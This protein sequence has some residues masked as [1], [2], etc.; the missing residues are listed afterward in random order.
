M[1]HV[2]LGLILMVS[3]SLIGCGS[4]SGGGPKHRPAATIKGF[5]VDAQIVGGTVSVFGFKNG[6]KG[7]LL[8]SAITDEQGF[9]RIDLAAPDQHILIEVKGGSY[10]EEA[11]G[12]G[13]TLKES[14]FMRAVTFYRSG[15]SVDLMITPFTH[16]AAGLVAYKVGQGVPVQ[17][18]VTEAS[19]AIS[20]LLGIDILSTVP[21]NITDPNNTNITMTDGLAYGF[22]AA[23]LSA[24]TAEASLQN[25]S[26]PHE[27]WTSIAFSQ[28][29]YRD[30][31]EDGLLDGKGKKTF[32]DSPVDLA[33][34]LVA[35]DANT[36]R[37][38]LAQKM[39][40]M[41]GSE[42]NRTG[43]RVEQALTQ[44]E[45]LALMTH[46]LFGGLAPVPLDSE[47]PIISPAEAE[48]LYHNE[49]FDF[50]VLVSDAVGLKTV[51]FDIDGTPIGQA[52]NP[53]LPSFPI[54][55]TLYEDGEYRI[56]V[57]AIDNLDN[58]SY[59]SFLIRFANNGS[60]VNLLSSNWVNQTPAVMSG[61]Y[62]DNGTGILGI[63]AN[64]ISADVDTELRTWTVEVPLTP[65][66]EGQEAAFVTTV[67]LEITDGLGVKNTELI[68]MTMDTFKP[69][70]DPVPQYSN[71]T[72]VIGESTFTEK[73]SFADESGIPIRIE[74]DKISLNGTPILEGPLTRA[75]IPYILL[76]VKDVNVNDVFTPEDEITAEI[77]YSLDGS[78]LSSW[79][80]LNPVITG[81]NDY[82][83]IVPLVSEG[84]HEDWHQ[85]TPENEHFIE[86]K[87]K[88]KAGNTN[89]FPFKFKAEFV[90]PPPEITGKPSGAL[91]VSFDQRTTLYG[92]TVP[93]VEYSI[94]NPTSQAVLFSLSSVT[95][96][97][98]SKVHDWA[99]RK[100]RAQLFNVEEWRV[101][102]RFTR[103]VIGLGLSESTVED[104]DAVWQPAEI[105]WAWVHNS[106]PE[107]STSLWPLYPSPPNPLSGEIDL[108]EDAYPPVTDEPTHINA[109]RDHHPFPSE[110]DGGPDELFVK[111]YN[112]FVRVGPWNSDTGKRDMSGIPFARDQ[113]LGHYLQSR[114]VTRWIS[115]YGPLNEIGTETETNPI[116]PESFIVRDGE[117]ARKLDQNGW[118][119]LP[120]GETYTI[121]STAVLPVLSFYNDTELSGVFETNYTLK[122]YDQ[123]IQWQIR[124]S[125]DV[126]VIHDAGPEKAPDML[127]Q[128]IS[129]KGDH[130][131]VQARP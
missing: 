91:A 87:I 81:N 56:G 45:H 85:S 10:T 29:M 76:H 25:G 110:E 49:T 67:S 3:L 68:S 90:P 32:N 111:P 13:V 80:T 2:G 48:G 95:D 112:Y 27:I 107:F 36:Y 41:V 14:Q 15:T 26:E 24:W 116:L 47:G 60:L 17:T 63:K 120:P 101:Q 129:I 74:T 109:W 53:S 98:V 54:N 94:N 92:K 124:E 50:K 58:E 19:T 86:V 21:L 126:Q 121:S 42:V 34:G 51:I 52:A 88:D 65:P 31:S 12:V 20:T 37:S 72:F 97:S 78:V 9:Y 38:E 8:G 73:L 102:E 40:F 61:N 43:I 105:I 57:K 22:W 123:S 6:V 104:P 114:I 23:G 117:A 118:F 35:L 127:A 125:L 99:V 64:G 71:A 122:R 131:A 46:E 5:A 103:Q 89:D 33:V 115:Q 7:D 83:F 77:Q 18:A 55:T 59:Q 113:S 82:R 79:H 75:N 108:F 106:T 96:H 70:F 93:L 4:N 119:R 30:I 11:S 1:K 69:K 100:H 44:A 16:I 28:V 62:I 130:N 39:M 84:L 66:I 128:L